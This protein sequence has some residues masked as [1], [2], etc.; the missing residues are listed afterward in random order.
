MCARRKRRL[1]PEEEAL[2]QRIAERVQPLH[3]GKPDHAG[4]GKPLKTVS[5]PAELPAQPA[6]I[7]GDLRIG[8]AAKPRPRGHD[9]AQ[10][11]GQRLAEAPVRMDRRAFDR[12]TRG[13]LAPEARIDLHGLTLAAAHPELI[14]F[15][16]ASAAGGLRLVL[17][18]TGK[19][20]AG[21]DDGPIPQ[22]PGVLKHQ[23]PH[24]LAAPPLAASVLQVT[25][26]HRRH[27]G[28]GA[29]YVYL[30]RAR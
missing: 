21:S 11:I 15:I 14:R 24:W 19:G 9:L 17:V 7:P 1:A 18:I 8:A 3:P 25:E 16:L 2:W 27:G 4:G 23:V 12:M 29:Y 26:A 10:S 5:R 22:R 28:S 30:R 20:R 6:A 13:R